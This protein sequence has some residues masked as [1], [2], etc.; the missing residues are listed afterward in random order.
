ML[1]NA[2]LVFQLDEAGLS[3][4]WKNL[5]VTHVYGDLGEL[6][7][8]D[9]LNTGYGGG[10]IEQITISAQER[11]RLF[12]EDTKSVSTVEKAK[13]MIGS[14]QCIVFL[15][16]GFLDQ[17]LLALRPQ[18]RSSV[19]EILS[20]SRGQSEDNQSILRDTLSTFFSNS[21]PNVRF[22]ANECGDIFKEYWSLLKQQLTSSTPFET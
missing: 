10:S 5:N 16:F 1:W 8:T 20:T 4:V 18:H 19:L 11:I 22:G 14:A 3:E 6:T 7:Y 9:L 13:Q 21:G 12:M 2:R 17:N 15:G